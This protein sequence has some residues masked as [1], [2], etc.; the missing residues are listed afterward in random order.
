MPAA[1]AQVLN[2]VSS[3][4][5]AEILRMVWN[6]ES[7]A[8]AINEAMPDVT[9]GAV[10]QHLK[11]L[12]EAGL[13][14]VRTEGRFRYYRAR[15]QALGSLKKV[16]EQMW[17]DSLWSLKLAAEMEEARRGPRAKAQRGRNTS[18]KGRKKS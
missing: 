7:T 18:K 3:P 10:S 11:R 5:R 6:K 9:F 14:E 2:V 15:Q 17:S 4:R 12:E 16:L 13:V 8:G 1:N